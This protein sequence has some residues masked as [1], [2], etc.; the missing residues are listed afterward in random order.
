[1]GE[2]ILALTMLILLLPSSHRDTLH[3]VLELCARVV[4]FEDENKMTLYNIAMIVAPNLFLPSNQRSKLN[5]RSEDKEQQ[6]N[7]EMTYANVTTQ[8]TQM[9]IKYRDVLWTVP[10]RLVSQI[11]RIYQA[12]ALKQSNYTPMRRLLTR[13]SK[14]TIQRPIENEVDYQEGVLRVSAPQFNKCNYPVKLDPLMTAKDLL[15]RFIEEL[16]VLPENPRRVEGRREQQYK[17]GSG[18]SGSPPS[19]APT[20]VSSPQFYACLLTGSLKKAVEQHALHERGGNIGDRRLDSKAKLL[21][22]YQ[23]NPN[24]EFIVKCHHHGGQTARRNS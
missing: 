17:R 4:A 12:E 14:E 10:Q 16:T 22:I 2:R 9:M 1:M 7:Y 24:A 19:T 11:R 5:L 21:T 15:T 13:K 20:S 8:L 3:A 6:L 23:D 18:G